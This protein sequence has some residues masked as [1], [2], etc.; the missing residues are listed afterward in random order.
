L[1]D[2]LHKLT[3]GTI[4]NI[5]DEDVHEGYIFND[6]GSNVY[7][8]LFMLLDEYTAK[9]SYTNL[10][11][12]VSNGGTIV[13]MDAN[14]MYAEI[15][16][17]PDLDTVT[18]L[19]GHGWKF[20]GHF[21][22]KNVHE[23]WLNENKD[24]IGSTFLWSHIDAPVTFSNNPFNYTHFEENYVSNPRAHILYDY[25][26]TIP[27]DTL[28]DNS[29]D[30]HLQIA[31]YSLQD[32]KGKVIY[33]GI[34]SH[35][36]FNNE[37]FL[38]FFD[39]LIFPQAV[40]QPYFSNNITLPTY[41]YLSTGNLSKIELKEPGHLTVDLIRNKNVN[42]RLI[43]TLP[44]QLISANGTKSFENLSVL[45]DDKKI[46]HDMFVGSNDVGITVPLF[47]QAQKVDIVS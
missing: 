21:A 41:Y 12:F 27:P 11:R 33:L 10:K 15:A 16:Y 31:T 42:D 23:R 46:K 37:V 40:G 3:N 39:N 47:P 8:V 6:N 5:S 28:R 18:L 19:R 17:N 43:L 25:G 34:Y 22:E 20:K 32:G 29:A 24:W 38:K 30:S 35:R 13:F 26:A 1:L 44:R 14:A 7:D 4:S 45:V 9:N 36:L 2:H